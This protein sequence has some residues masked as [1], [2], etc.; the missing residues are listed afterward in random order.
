MYNVQK[1]KI[2]VSENSLNL[3]FDEYKNLL[4]LAGQQEHPEIRASSHSIHTIRKL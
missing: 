1:M 4:K 2:I 3:F